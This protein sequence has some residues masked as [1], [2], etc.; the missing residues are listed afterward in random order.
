M[1]REGVRVTMVIVVT[2]AL[3]I[4]GLLCYDTILH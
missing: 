4:I 1:T 3:T 2:F